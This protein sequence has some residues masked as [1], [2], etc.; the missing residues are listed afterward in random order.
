VAIRAWRRFQELIYYSGECLTIELAA[1]RRPRGAVRWFFRLPVGLYR[2]GFGWLV[3]HVVIVV[4]TRGRRTGKP[5]ANAMRYEHDSLTDTY[6]VLSGWEGRTDWY[7]NAVNDSRVH[8]RVG[9]R[10]FWT[11][12]KPLDAEGVRRVLRT[13]LARNPFAVRTIRRETGVAYDGSEER[14]R[15]IASHYP[16]MA[17]PGRPA[18]STVIDAPQM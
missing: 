5:H 3:S 18:R 11:V 16:A 10:S 6:F 9:T 4:T 14:L 17:L 13:Y 12:A 1:R 7:R 15:E 8:V 2:S